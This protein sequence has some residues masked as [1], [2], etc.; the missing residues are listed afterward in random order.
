MHDDGPFPLIPVLSSPSLA[1]AG[2]KHA[3]TTR[4]GGVSPAP[5]E[6]LD[7]ATLR[8]PGRL[9]ENQERLARAVGFDRGVF[10]QSRQVHG[11]ALV[12]ADGDPARVLER[13][14]DALV[15]EPG[16]ARAVAIRVADCV[17]VLVADTHSGRVGAAH[18][19]WRGVEAGVVAATVEQLATSRGAGS[20]GAFVAAIGPSIGPCCFEV[21]SEVAERIARAA[22]DDRVIVSR[23][24]DGAK[25]MVDLRRAVRAQLER[26]G[27]DD[28]VIDDVPGCTRC[29]RERFYSYRRDGDESGRLVGVIVA[30]A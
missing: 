15:A 9:R 4:A 26:L 13:E 21:G 1:K 25:A 10:Y 11:R 14:A 3:F 30:R 19:G 28:A 8:D 20:P 12:V 2:F 16:T 7:F 6:S 5:Y 23:H 18:A 17:P 27:L 22:Q 24:A 29:E